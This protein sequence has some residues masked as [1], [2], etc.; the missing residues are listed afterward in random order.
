MFI[1]ECRI[2]EIRIAILIINK[3]YVLATVTKLHIFQV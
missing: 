1:F 3:K 2:Q